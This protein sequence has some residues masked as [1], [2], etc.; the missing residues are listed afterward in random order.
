MHVH[1][2]VCVFGVGIILSYLQIDNSLHLTFPGDLSLWNV[3]K[4]F[5][6]KNEQTKKP[7]REQTTWKHSGQE[8]KIKARR[9][10]FV[11]SRAI[12]T[13]QSFQSF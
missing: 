6:K 5:K 9:S 7:T 8:I 10:H 4:K 13:S 12:K 2:C 1:V 3:P 11:H